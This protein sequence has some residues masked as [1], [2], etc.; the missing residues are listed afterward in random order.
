LQGYAALL[1]LAK[2]ADGIRGVDINHMYVAEG[3]RRQG[4]GRKLIDAATDVAR[5]LGCAYLFIGTAPDN[6]AA[7]EAYL[8]CGFARW[9][10]GGPR[11]RLPIA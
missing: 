10:D 6:I 11:F 2:I 3:L 7:Q 4:I 1:P 5:T 9:T 8:A